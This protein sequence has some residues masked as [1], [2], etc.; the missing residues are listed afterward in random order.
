MQMLGDAAVKLLQLDLDGTYEDYEEYI[1]NIDYLHS[2]LRQTNV[3][4]LT[5]ILSALLTVR[6]LYIET[7][8]KKYLYKIHR[9]NTRSELKYLRFAFLRLV[10]WSEDVESSLQNFGS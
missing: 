9:F 8:M 10:D 2:K 7:Y 1:G 5:I 6:Y 4:I 3:I